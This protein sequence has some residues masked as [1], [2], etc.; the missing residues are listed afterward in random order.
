MNNFIIL[1]KK[2]YV[3]GVPFNST[4][5]SED[6]FLITDD[7]YDQYD[8]DNDERSIL[9]FGDFI[10]TAELLLATKEDDIPKLKGNFYALVLNQG[11]VKV[12]SSFFNILPL[13]STQDKT[14]VASSLQLIEANYHAKLT[15]N[16][17]IILENLLF[18]YSLFNDTKYNEVA[19]VPCH[20]HV[21][22]AGQE[23]SLR[24]HFETTSLFTQIPSSG[25][26]VVNDLSDLFIDTVKDYFPAT[27]FAIA[28]TGGF[29]GRTLV[30][31][32]LNHQKRF[33]TFSFGRPEN[34]DVSI[35]SKNADELGI[36]YRFDDLG[37]QEYIE[38]QYYEHATKFSK[39][40]N[41]GN[42][43][44]YAHFSY[45]AQKV[46]E[47]SDYLLSGACGSELFRALH[48]R[49]AV[50][51]TA[52]VDIF[53]TEDEQ[54]IREK[55]TSSQVLK[56]V[57]LED[58]KEELDSLVFDVI[59]YKR[60][61]PQNCSLNQQFY[62]FVFE[63]IFRKF[64]GQW[65]VAQQRYL[66]VRTPFLDFNFV[67]ALLQTEYAGANNDFFTS[68][69]LKR[70]KGQMVYADIIKKTN[71]A[72]YRQQTGKGY[73]PRAVRNVL[74]SY[75]IFLPFLKK[76]FKRKLTKTYL[77]NLGIVSGMLH[78]SKAMEELISETTFFK[79]KELKNLLL[80]LT[81]YTP[82]QE[83]DLLAMSLSIVFNLQKKQQQ[84]KPQIV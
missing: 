53:S 26:K 67:K 79:K 58:F 80:G 18:N 66:K 25:K 5:L 44:L 45:N 71:H 68:H 36:P 10:G 12:Y 56:V 28:F 38:E 83:R 74:F 21:L 4:M 9:V 34:S 42:G 16:K 70:R 57:C 40:G 8:D 51:S 76:R 52:L 7:H 15:V 48:I 77:D 84:Q 17:R 61:I 11:T 30:S 22:L 19:L 32:A 81:P 49:G 13:Y 35:P 33:D 23:L 27:N 3:L 24:K 29:D 14:M 43:L 55:L 72:I 46:S 6:W 31:C 47:H 59:R 73:S 50:T 62:L 39:A 1:N 63:E 60:K 2:A 54:M 65:I 75:Q 82:E 20:H 64:F 41:I 78:N 37:A 69:P